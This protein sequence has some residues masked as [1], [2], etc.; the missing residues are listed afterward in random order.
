MKA[1][2]TIEF[3]HTNSLKLS[4]QR[5]RAEYKE[6]GARGVGGVSRMDSRPCVLVS[7]YI[8]GT[9]KCIQEDMEFKASSHCTGR[10]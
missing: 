10:P 7:P 6:K 8:T 2:L 3:I 4:C 9:E 1:Q 5:E